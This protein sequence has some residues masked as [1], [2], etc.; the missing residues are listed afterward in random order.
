MTQV[1]GFGQVSPLEIIPLAGYKGTPDWRAGF[2]EDDDDTV[3]LFVEGSR[4]VAEASILHP[5][6]HTVFIDNFECREP[7]K[8][9]G[10]RCISLLKTTYKLKGYD[11]IYGES[12]PQASIFW[13]KQG[14]EF[15]AI[16]EHAE[17]LY[18][19]LEPFHI[20]L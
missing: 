4:V 20:K 19:N 9:I 15:R 7:G 12:V 16:D 5:D 8:G 1:I 3:F 17:E 2:N 11:K 13:L 18:P 10:R 6:S 14:A